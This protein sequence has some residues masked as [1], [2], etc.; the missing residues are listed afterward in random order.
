MVVNVAA[1]YWKAGQ[2]GFQK[3]CQDI[4]LA[5]SAPTSPRPEVRR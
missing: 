5:P 1:D 2:V 3:G 4:G